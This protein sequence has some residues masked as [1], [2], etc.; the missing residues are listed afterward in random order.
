MTGQ[1]D[2]HQVEVAI[3]AWL[4]VLDDLTYY[5]LLSIDEGAS[6]AEL[7]AA[8]HR[9]AQSF[10]PDRHRQRS[11]EL[12]AAVTKIFRKATEGYRVLG[13][14]RERSRYDLDLARTRARLSGAPP[15]ERPQS[16][17]DLCSTPGGR[18]HGRQAERALSEGD[19]EKAVELIDRALLAEGTSPQL[20]ARKRAVSD[21]IELASVPPEAEVVVPDSTSLPQGLDELMSSL[22]PLHAEIASRPDF[23]K[24]GE[25]LPN[26][27]KEPPVAA[28]APGPVS[29]NAHEEAQTSARPS[30]KGQEPRGSTTPPG[31]DEEKKEA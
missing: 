20:E 31:T 26:S 7:Q 19:L 1:S 9:F 15:S 11:E 4:E 2:N 10:H 17:E 14:Q 12:R 30:R 16:L 8:F 24:Q 5:E 25:P 29:A 3:L 18:L 27:S 6:S 28:V 13:S 22:T 23:P 21:A